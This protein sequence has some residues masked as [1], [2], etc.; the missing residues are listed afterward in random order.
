MLIFN[1]V[2]AQNAIVNLPSCFKKTGKILGRHTTSWNF[3][4][5]LS[6]LKICFLSQLMPS[7]LYVV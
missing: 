7:A 5:T 2:V 3:A 1:S 6:D 4:K